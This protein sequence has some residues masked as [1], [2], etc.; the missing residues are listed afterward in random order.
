MS[1]LL[2]AIPSPFTGTGDG[3]SAWP[4]LYARD[5]AAAPRMHFYTI[6]SVGVENPLLS[7]NGSL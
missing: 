3:V 7:G 5:S 4:A 1:Y 2:A 6:A